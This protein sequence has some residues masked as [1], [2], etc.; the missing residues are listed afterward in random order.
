MISIQGNA[1]MFVNIANW[2][3]RQDDLIAIRP[4]GEGDQ[5]ITLTVVQLRALGWFSVV[6]V[7]AIIVLS[8]L[9]VWWRRR[10]GDATGH[11]R[12]TRAHPDRDRQ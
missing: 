5:R 1:D 10:A 8:G 2:L 4:R 3:T 6:V 11:R 12:A 9:R 7:P